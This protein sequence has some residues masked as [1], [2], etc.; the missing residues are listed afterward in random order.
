[1]IGHRHCRPGRIV[2][3]E[4]NTDTSEDPFS[5]D[6]DVGTTKYLAMIRVCLIV[7]ING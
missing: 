2:A 3:N 6:K 7:L 4:P 5:N 1:M